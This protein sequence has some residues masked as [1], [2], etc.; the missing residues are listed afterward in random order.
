MSHPVTTIPPAGAP[1]SA[2]P[3]AMPPNLP[4]HPDEPTPLGH[5]IRRTFALAA[6]IIVARTALIV[7]FTVDTI[8]SGWSGSAQLAYL[9]LGVAPQLVLMLVAMGA[10]QSTVVLTAQ[11]IGAGEAKRTGAILRASALHAGILGIVICALS[12]LAKPFFLLTGQQPDLAAGAARVTLQFAWGVPAVLFFMTANLFL[13][14]TGYPRVGMWIM[15][16]ANVANVILNGVFALGW[17]ALFPPLG[18]EGAVIA[19]SA[20]RWAALVAVFTFILRLAL[21]EDDP[22]GVIAAFTEARALRHSLAGTTGRQIR[23]I[24]VPMGIAQGVESAAFTTVVLMAGTLGTSAAAAHQVTMSVVTFVFM[25]A[26]GTAGA[27][28]IRV[29]N[30]VG[31]GNALDVRR[32]GWTGIAIGALLPVPFSILFLVAPDAPARL[33]STDPAVLAITHKTVFI[34]GFLLSFDAAMG[35]TLGA[36]RG[37]GDVWMPMIMQ[38]AAFWCFGIPAAYGLAFVAG[39]GPPGLFAAI[40]V[41]IL[42]SLLLLIPRFT[43]IIRGEIKRL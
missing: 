6:P 36:L 41:G 33:F 15:L 7:M 16:A 30:A 19:S 9:G 3:P 5:H 17:F 18:A 22:F 35:V 27:T 39:F 31:R 14:A 40:G 2:V 32:A 24:G 21:R 4:A 12:L 10:L 37:L 25:M 42:A 23:S 43:L 38:A 11:A 1:P 29:G 8:M 34:A 28:A 26:I 13:E 20:L